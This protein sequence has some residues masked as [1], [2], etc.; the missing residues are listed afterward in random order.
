MRSASIGTREASLSQR[1]ESTRRQAGFTLV[2][3]LVALSLVLALA[4]ALGPLYFH[5]RQILL[6][7]GGQIRAQILLRTLLQEPFD[8][9]SPPQEG[10]RE[11]AAGDLRWRLDVEPVNTAPS[12][13]PRDPAPDRQLKWSLFH[14]TA[15]V[16]WGAGRIV[17]GETLRL[18][19]GN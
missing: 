3:T 11:G 19:K 10:I 15:H 13:A 4:A 16:F 17:K 7:G 1:V 2:E 5:S 6:K 12:D 18:G 14:V 8:R 9:V